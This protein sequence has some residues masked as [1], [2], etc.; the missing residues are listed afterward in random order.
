VA[1][2]DPALE[3][4]DRSGEILAPSEHTV[5]DLGVGKHFRQ[6]P[7]SLGAQEIASSGER[8]GPN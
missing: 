3:I 7:A 1:D 2:V 5:G 4:L 6:R 8:G